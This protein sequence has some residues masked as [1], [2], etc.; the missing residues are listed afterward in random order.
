[1]IEKKRTLWRRLWPFLRPYG[2]RLAIL[3]VLLVVNNLLTLCI[4]ML[5]GWAVGAVGSEP[6]AVDF[7]AVGRNC[8]GMLACCVGASALNYLVSSRLIRLAQSV[9]YDLRR[10]AFDRLSE[11]PVEYF[12]THP[13][14]DLI[15]RICYDVDTV[16]ATLSTDLLQIATSFLT[17]GGSFIMLLLLSPKLSL[18][19][20]VTVP[21]SVALT[22]FQMRRIQPLFRR[23]SRE[24]GA[25]N[26]FA[27]ERMGCPAGHAGST[28][29]RRQTSGSSRLST[30]LRPGP[31]T[32]RTG[33]VWPWGRR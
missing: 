6:G 25:L 7:G 8:A 21:L 33:P 24:L 26:G 10:A 9:S 12:D 17:V 27:E 18:V 29:W 15:S 1:M 16:N 5:S 28:A 4:P 2:A 14:G 23:R 32:R 13:A 20:F 3:A 19:F 22:R 30:S 11:L 31:T